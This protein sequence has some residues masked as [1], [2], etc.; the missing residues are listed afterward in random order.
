MKSEVLVSVCMTAY[1]Q[2]KFIVEAIEGV[3]MQQ[4]DF[5]FEL[6]I[7]EDFSMKDNTLDI[8]LNYQKKYPEIIR[9]VHDKKNHGMVANEQ[10]LMDLA[11]GKYI[12]FCE[13]DDY[14][15]HP[16]KLQKQVNILENNLQFAACASQSRVIYEVD[17][18]H[19]HL[20]SDAS[21]IDR[22]VTLQD[23]LNGTGGFQ[24]AS[25][26]F[27]TKYIH[28][29]PPMPIVINGWDRAVFILNAY[30]GI[31]YWFNE[32]MT[33]YRKNESGI[34]TQVS[35]D[36]MAKDVE[37]IDWFMSID[38][39]FPINALKAYIYESMISNART[40]SNLQLI[41][42]YLAAQYYANKSPMDMSV[43]KISANKTL[44]YRLPKNTRRFFRIIGIVKNYE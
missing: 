17:K 37:M 25:F 12:A 4:T 38:K 16:L 20:L 18:E 3:L 8:C 7:G 21:L 27:R 34:S 29:V 40:I 13:A 41:I 26:M 39:K 36:K 28:E 1:N 10:R 33:V 19:W 15:I 22:Q 44:A 30:R 9:I 2:A 6:L 5:P 42:Y 35:F 24:T 43:L 14:W 31:I 23:Q 32:P 11:E